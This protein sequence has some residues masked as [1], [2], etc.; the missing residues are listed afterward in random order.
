[1]WNDQQ[2]KLVQKRLQLLNHLET[3]KLHFKGRSEKVYDNLTGEHLYHEYDG[4]RI[5]LALTCFD[6]LGQPSEWLDF[7]SWLISSKVKN[8]RDNIFKEIRNS[9]TNEYVSKIF[10]EYQKIYSVKNSFFRFTEKI[11]SEGN[12]DKLF[13]SIKASVQLTP[14]MTHGNYTQVPTGKHYTLTTEMKKRFL[15]EI[16]NSYTHKGISA[17]NG[18]HGIYN[19]EAPFFTW[20]NFD[21][22]NVYFPIYKNKIDGK[23]I[24]YRVKSW[25]YCLIEIIKDTITTK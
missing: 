24:T 25:P 20:G 7:K 22:N 16:R 1:M 12:K 4:L 13:N 14:E 18:I 19:L 10:Q 11:L 5:Y 15:F 2:I 6:I 9:T 23:I 3:L 8:E 21:Y 17:A